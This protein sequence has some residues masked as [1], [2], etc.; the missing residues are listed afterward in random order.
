MGIVEEIQVAIKNLLPGITG[1]AQIDYEYNIELNSDRGYEK[2]FGFIPGLA[3]FAEGRAMGFTTMNHNYQLVLTDDYMNKDCDTPQNDIIMAMYA[4]VQDTLK[5]LQKS[6]L[7]LPT[8]GN[9]VL[10]ISGLTIDDPEFSE[11]NSV[12]ALRSNF[13]I[14]YQ[15]KNV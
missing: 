9:R 12:A 6:R 13:V 1:H 14:Q 15:Y 11:D 4:G 3:T 2:R 10:L 8:I 5:Q 7:A